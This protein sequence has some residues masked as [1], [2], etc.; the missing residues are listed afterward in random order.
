MMRPIA[1]PFS[2]RITQAKRVYC[3]QTKA[4]VNFTGENEQVLQ[5][6]GFSDNYHPNADKWTASRT[7]SLQ[8]ALRGLYHGMVLQTR[9]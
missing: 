7:L 2:S 6:I 9:H 8:A 4:A 3:G 1:Q 5:T